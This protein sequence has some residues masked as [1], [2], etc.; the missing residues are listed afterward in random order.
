MEH[1]PELFV[2]I[3]IYFVKGRPWPHV[4]V[5]VTPATQD[6]VQVF[7]PSGHRSAHMLVNNVSRLAD[8]G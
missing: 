2:N 4:P 6:D 5:I 8:N 1:T 3:L 7:H